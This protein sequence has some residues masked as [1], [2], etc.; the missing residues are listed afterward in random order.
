MR[1]WFT[2]SV[3]LG[4]V[5]LAFAAIFVFNAR[6]PVQLM[7]KNTTTETARSVRVFDERGRFSATIESIPAGSFIELRFPPH[8]EADYRVE[9]ELPAGRFTS[10]SQYTDVSK[11]FEFQIASPT[12]P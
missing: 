2:I 12:G 5:I 10:P 11:S 3:V 4:L 6:A 9:A 8:G 7:V 1:A